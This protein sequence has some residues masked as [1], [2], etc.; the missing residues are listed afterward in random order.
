MD[1]ITVAPTDYIARKLDQAVTSIEAAGSGHVDVG[2]QLYLMREG[3]R[4]L[5]SAM[6]SLLTEFQQSGNA[7]EELD[8]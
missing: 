7:T 1:E 8:A 2:G 6:R 5:E 4:H 3:M